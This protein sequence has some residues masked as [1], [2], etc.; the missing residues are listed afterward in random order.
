M[1]T[2]VP[3]MEVLLPYLDPGDREGDTGRLARDCTANP[4]LGAVCYSTPTR[5][6]SNT[7]HPTYIAL[8]RFYEKKRGTSNCFLGKKGVTHTMWLSQSPEPH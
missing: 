1:N 4:T 8:N 7:L 5:C 3:A 2:L 6:P